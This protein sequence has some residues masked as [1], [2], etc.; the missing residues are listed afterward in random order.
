MGG[1]RWGSSSPNTPL[2]FRR[3][4]LAAAAPRPPHAAITTLCSQGHGAAPNGPLLRTSPLLPQR[5]RPPRTRVP[6]STPASR[7]QHLQPLHHQRLTLHH[8]AEALAM[9][10]FEGGAQIARAVRVAPGHLQAP[11]A[12]RG[13]QLQ[14]HQGGRTVAGA[15][16]GLLQGLAGLG[17]QVIATPAQL[18]QQ[19]RLQ[20]QLHRLVAQRLLPREPEA[21]GREHP[22]QGMEQHP[23]H[24]EPLG[25]GAGV[26]AAGAA[27]AHEHG[28]ADVVAALD[29]DAS[30]RIGHPLKGDAAGALGK[31]LRR[32]KRWRPRE[33]HR[34]WPE[35]SHRLYPE[36]SPRLHPGNAR[37]RSFGPSIGLDLLPG[38]I[39][40]T[41]RLVRR[42][43]RRRSRRRR[44]YRPLNQLG[45][46]R[47]EAAPHDRGV[48][49]LI[50]SGPEHRRQG[51]L[52]QTPQQQV[53]VGDGERPATAIAG[54]PRN[55]SGR[56][57]SHLQPTALQ[58]HHRTATGR[59]RVDRQGGGLQTEARHGGFRAELDASARLQMEHIGGG[60]AHVEAEDRPL[61]QAS[62]VSHRHGA[63]QA[64]GGS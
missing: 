24:A 20:T 28:G 11:L 27:V 23:L 41:V 55:R 4:G 60:S 37:P 33:S 58:P 56:L 15:I 40:P 21:I 10:R 53:R 29:R 1:L 2:E 50:A 62:G 46:Q 9:T 16:A 30:D 22:G 44:A 51:P 35:E 7:Q 14:A 43:S 45:G 26:L 25:Q 59:H 64:P 57:R 18:T 3:R 6:R 63:P 42:R 19:G 49:G 38:L 54:R 36:E 31:G 48:G 12:A 8:E 39:A 47:L 52:R 17:Q 13:P 5:W 34:L 32:E 61:R